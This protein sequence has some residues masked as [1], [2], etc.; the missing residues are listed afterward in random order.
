MP[1]LKPASGTDEGATGPRLDL[2]LEPGAQVVINVWDRSLRQCLLKSIVGR[3]KA[4]RMKARKVLE[5]RPCGAGRAPGN[6]RRCRWLLF[7]Q[8]IYVC[9]DDSLPGALA[10]SKATIVPETFGI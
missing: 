2:R 6:Y 3:R 9:L 5:D 7:T 10:P 8:K 4:E 1:N